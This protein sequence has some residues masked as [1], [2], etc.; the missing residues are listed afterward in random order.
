MELKRLNPA[1]SATVQGS[2]PPPVV[3]QITDATARQP[4]VIQIMTD[5]LAEAGFD[6][7]RKQDRIVDSGR[8]YTLTD[9]AGVYD[10]A[11]L[12]GWTLICQ[13]GS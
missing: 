7:P 2:A 3:A 8:E 13:G 6:R 5:G 1:L 9:A 4:L 10:G 12:I 11:T